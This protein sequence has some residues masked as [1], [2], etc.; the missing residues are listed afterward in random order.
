MISWLIAN[1]F[2]PIS[3]STSLV[4]SF[5]IDGTNFF[6][7][8]SDDTYS[9]SGKTTNFTS[10]NSL[11]TT[12]RQTITQ[13]INDQRGEAFLSGS[14]YSTAETIIT[15]STFFVETSTVETYESWYDTFT[16][17]TDA[18][19]APFWTTSLRTSGSVSFYQDEGT[20]VTVTQV[21]STTRRATRD[22][23]TT[24]GETAVGR[25]PFAT[26]YQ[27]ESEEVLYAVSNPLQP[28]SGFSAASSV[29]KSGTRTTAYPSYLTGS[30]IIVEG[31]Q[32]TTRSFAQSEYSAAVPVQ[33]SV[34]T[35]QAVTIGQA[36]TILPNLTVAATQTGRTTTNQ[37]IS[38]TLFFE[39]EFDLGYDGIFRPQ[40][41]I[42]TRSAVSWA[43]YPTTVFRQ[44]GPQTFQA[45]Q[46]TATSRSESFR[47]AAIAT[48]A[49]SYE[50]GYLVGLVAVQTI[51]QTYAAGGN[52][53]I[54]HGGKL[55]TAIGGNI[56]RHA[57][58]T[59]GVVLGSQT[60]GWMSLAG[61]QSVTLY[62]GA[63]G[64]AT[65]YAGDNV[66]GRT[67]L[68]LT[69][70]SLTIDQDSITWTLSTVAAQGEAT[71]TTSSSVVQVAGSSLTTS[72]NTNGRPLHAGAELVGVGATYVDT[73]GQGVYRDQINGET[74]SF[75]GDAT[76][77][78]EGQSAQMRRWLPITFLDFPQAGTNADPIVWAVPRNSTN[79]PPA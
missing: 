23:T 48:S 61:A 69:N 24:N 3:A 51:G 1:T 5:S 13:T 6:P 50:V 58:S 36:F 12:Q 20:V 44:S 22:T 54:H 25:S 28:W 64:F 59:T 16:T 33:G 78:T 70:S 11:G 32:T 79:L 31:G 9:L 19:V 18:G 10:E 56:T 8:S 39:N 2:D 15:A 27:V 49:I 52:E 37:T 41:S 38:T 53:I 17:I 72:A 42:T 67:V 68:P 47:V 35:S 74:T 34:Q 77:Y 66:G 4:N 73:P 76:A 30:K 63:G 71:S 75:I 7:T 55:R 62:D 14:T 45:T 65:A 46:K 26:V 21:E 57:F 60:G 40:Q 29:A 43:T